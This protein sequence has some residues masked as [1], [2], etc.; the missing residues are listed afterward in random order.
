MAKQLFKLDELKPAAPVQSDKSDLLAVKFLNA[1]SR[2]LRWVKELSDR[3]PEP[4]EIFFIWTI[5]QFNAFTFIPWIL[6]ISNP[7][8]ELIIT[9]YSINTKII[10]S[11]AK[12]LR[13]GMVKYLHIVISDSV[14]FRIPKVIDELTQLSQGF[15][16]RADITYA[17]NHSKVSLVKLRDHSLIIEGSGNFS[18]NSRHEQY[19]ISN[20]PEVYDFR[21]KWIVDD[22]HGKTT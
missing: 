5:N 15:P 13:N 18:E 2:K 16:D 3:L 14:K 8:D 12:Y 11:L 9:T 21:K 7:I 10:R 6:S 1:H 20:K 19:I 17:W 4:G 22:I